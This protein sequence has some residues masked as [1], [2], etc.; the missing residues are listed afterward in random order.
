ME[1]SENKILILFDGVCNFCDDAVN[2]VIKRDKKNIF[3][4]TPLQS[5]TGQEFLLKHKLDTVDLR[6][7]IVVKDG[8]L[9][10]KSNASLLITRHLPFPWPLLYIFKLVPFFIR[11]FFYDLFAKNRY[12]FF[13]KKE[14]CMIPTA[15]VRA[16]FLD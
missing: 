16:K 4:F 7:M 12:H 15:E 1:K 9:F 13:G 5:V 11:D 3:I 2:F 6:S 10:R 14:S 8:K